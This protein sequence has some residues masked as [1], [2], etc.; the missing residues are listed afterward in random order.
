MTLLTWLRRLSPSSL[1]GVKPSAQSHKRDHA[2]AFQ[3][4]GRA[5]DRRLGNR[6]VC[7][8][9]AFDFGGSQPMA[10]NIED[11]I[12]AT[13]DPEVAILVSPRAVAGEIAALDFAPVLLL[14][15]SVVAV[16]RSQHRWPWFADDELAA[17]IWSDL[18]ALVVDDGGIDAKK[19][20]GSRS[21]FS[22][23]GAGQA[24]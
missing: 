15:P 22:R 10:R 9:R 23:R 12:D 21:G 14:E 6:F 18:F 19:G 7:D 20:Q 11:V 8:Q 1:L 5:D 17:L 3:F 24:E 4:V 2:L 16:N 13:N